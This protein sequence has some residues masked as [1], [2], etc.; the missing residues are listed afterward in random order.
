MSEGPP[1]RLFF[2]HIQKTAGTT[3][4]SM[5]DAAFGASQVYPE[6]V[7]S[8]E[9][10]P[11]DALARY[12]SIYRLLDDDRL[13]DYRA[14]VGHIPLAAA[15]LLPFPVQKATVLRNPVDRAISMLSQVRRSSLGDRSED[16]VDPCDESEAELCRS[17]DVHPYV[18]RRV[19]CGPRIESTW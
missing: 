14:F 11:L 15:E 12:T 1:E 3:F 6:I 19:C 18:P 5:L 10:N 13:H 7:E 16:R 4:R 8:V 2:V 9:R 17:V